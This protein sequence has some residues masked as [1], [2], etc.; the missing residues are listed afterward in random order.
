MPVEQTPPGSPGGV[1]ESTAALLTSGA[2]S[3]LV[4]MVATVP[5]P[6]ANAKPAGSPMT[7]S[8]IVPSTPTTPSASVTVS[9]PPTTMKP[10]GLLN[11]SVVSNDGNT[12]WNSSG[13]TCGTADS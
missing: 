10:V 6:M 5:M 2:A 4:V 3:Q 8:M 1:L 13:L 7:V 9:A 11:Q 12:T